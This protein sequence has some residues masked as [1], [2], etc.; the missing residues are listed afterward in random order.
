M[1]ASRIASGE[2]TFVSRKPRK[3]IIGF[4]I[5][6]RDLSAIVSFIAVQG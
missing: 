5:T 6:S 3:T 1:I 2:D 4:S